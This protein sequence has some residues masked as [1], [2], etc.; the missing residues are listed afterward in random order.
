MCVRVCVVVCVR[1]Y[2]VYVCVWLCVCVCMWRECKVVCRTNWHYNLIA[3]QIVHIITTGRIVKW[4]AVHVR[5][6]GATRGSKDGHSPRGC[7][8]WYTA[9]DLCNT[10]ICCKS[11]ASL[12]GLW[13]CY[14]GKEI[15]LRLLLLYGST[16]R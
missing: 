8:T 10:Y 12:I 4:N 16:R 15:Q 5:R 6:D 14:L 9:A 7:M 2:V 3:L 13:S 11:I 1:V